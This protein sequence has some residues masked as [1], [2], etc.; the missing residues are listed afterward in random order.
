MADAL[1]TT[2]T[3]YDPEN[4]LPIQPHQWGIRVEFAPTGPG[5]SIPGGTWGFEAPNGLWAKAMEMGLNKLTDQEWADL[6]ST[7]QVV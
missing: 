4:L 6:Q 1:V 2:L 5:G 3:D 7:Y